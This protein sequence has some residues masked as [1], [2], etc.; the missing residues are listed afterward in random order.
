MV[1]EEKGIE[2]DIRLDLS[3]HRMECQIEHFTDNVND[4]DN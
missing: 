2:K 1:K 4:D 3:W